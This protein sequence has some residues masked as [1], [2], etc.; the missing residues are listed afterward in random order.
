MWG[1]V[2]AE[3]GSRQ[4]LTQHNDQFNCCGSRT[5]EKGHS[6]LNINLPRIKGKYVIGMK[7]VA[8]QCWG[9]AIKMMITFR[10]RWLNLKWF[11]EL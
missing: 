6:L 11:D 7:F 10:L 9:S 1:N 5:I 2:E 3:Q 4:N 8:V